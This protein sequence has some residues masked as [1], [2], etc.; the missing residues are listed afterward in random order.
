ME[1]SLGVGDGVK[2][3]ESWGIDLV[4]KL[5]KGLIMPTGDELHRE[6]IE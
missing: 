5:K 4:G 3:G 1:Q 2:S 6:N